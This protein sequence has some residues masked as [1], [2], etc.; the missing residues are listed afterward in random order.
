MLFDRLLE[1]LTCEG[2]F[3]HWE[4]IT[5]AGFQFRTSLLSDGISP[6]PNCGLPFLPPLPPFRLL[7][8]FRTF[9]IHSPFVSSSSRTTQDV[10]LSTHTRPLSCCNQAL[11]FLVNFA[12]K[13][14][15]KNS[16]AIEVLVLATLTPSPSPSGYIIKVRPRPGTRASCA[17]PQRR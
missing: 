15:S 5:R 17:C 6:S 1:L 4:L 11:N 16:F 12:G 3:R 10:M 9:P 13:A 8:S 14:V 2:E 7:P